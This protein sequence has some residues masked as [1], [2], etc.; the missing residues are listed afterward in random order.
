MK[1][2]AYIRTWHDRRDDG[3]RQLEAIRQFVEGSR[4]QLT[5]VYAEPS[6]SRTDR[7]QFRRLLAAAEQ[8]TVDVIVIERLDR[9]AGSLRELVEVFETVRR[10]RVALVCLEEQIN[11]ST[12]GGDLVF[13]VMR[14]VGQFER[15]LHGKRIRVGLARARVLGTRLGRPPAGVDPATVV[16]LRE[17]ALS[18]RQ[19]GRRLGISPALAHRLAR[20]S[21]PR[22]PEA[23][24]KPLP[25]I[26]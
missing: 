22:P 24:Q 8:R 13:D 25:Q 20:R 11:T 16:Q 15:R 19:I 3:D 9:V 12:H 4:W 6:G 5:G 10:C 18:Y 17:Q 1:A 2:A 26:L 14:V 23:V 21:S 7:P